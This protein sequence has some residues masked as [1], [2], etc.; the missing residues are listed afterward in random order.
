MIFS[1]RVSFFLFFL[2]ICLVFTSCLF[3]PERSV[4]NKMA[5]PRNTYSAKTNKGNLVA[6]YAELLGVHEKDI[7]NIELY[8]FIDEW[9]GAPHRLGGQ[10]K[11]GIDCSGFINQLYN[12]VYD[13]TIPRASY[14]MAEVVKRK[15]ENQLVEGD[16]IFFSFGKGKVDHVGMYLRNNKFVHV[17]TSKGVIISDL[18]ET[19]FY[20]YF[21][22]GGTVK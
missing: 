14:E 13:K 12:Q 17:S 9:M 8:S 4:N 1:K 3:R 5:N 15:Y 21:V 16:L 19:W 22:R 11:S 18:H 2:A 6:N 20:K 10:L 7:G